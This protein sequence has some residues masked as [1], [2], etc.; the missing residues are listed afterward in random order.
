MS[1]NPFDD[2]GQKETGGNPFENKEA[3]GGV[4][5]SSNPFGDGDNTNP[6]SVSN[7][8][9]DLDAMSFLQVPTMPPP[10]T[11]PPSPPPTDSEAEESPKGIKRKTRRKK[12]KGGSAPVQPPI[13]TSYGLDPSLDTSG[14]IN[15][16][17][18]VGLSNS[19]LPEIVVKMRTANIALCS[20]GILF[21]LVLLLEKIARP[22]DLML[23]GY[24][25]FFCVLLLGFEVHTP[26]MDE[27]LVDNFGI[28]FFPG[29]RSLLMFLMGT[30]AFGQEGVI[31]IL[32]GICFIANSFFTVYINFKHKD[33]KH[34]HQRTDREDLVQKATEYAW[35]TAGKEVLRNATTPSESTGLL[36]GGANGSGGGF[37]GY[38]QL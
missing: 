27:F 29:G 14:D 19:N 38:S 9:Q 37:G 25:I 24:L 31:D 32:L 10:E 11:P 18:N 15:L 8:N 4:A 28:L 16:R 5:P 6:S 21:E 7:V 26:K 3:M 36:S 12:N 17:P 23:S 20:L 13:I 34:V 30:M 1:S 33:F 22:I 2:A 35:T